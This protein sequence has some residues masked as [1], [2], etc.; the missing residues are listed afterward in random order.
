MSALPHEPPHVPTMDQIRDMLPPGDQADYDR[1]RSQAT[2]QTIAA[3]AD[4][5]WSFALLY[6]RP[7]FGDVAQSAW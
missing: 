5:W 3:V 7:G 1:E 4:K 2:P 6:R